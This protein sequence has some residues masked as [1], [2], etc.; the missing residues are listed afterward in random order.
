[1]RDLNVVV[2][3]YN[4]ANDLERFIKSFV[5]FPVEKYRMRMMVENVDPTIEERVAVDRIVERFKESLDVS[6]NHIGW[7]CGY[8]HAVNV[9]MG[10]LHEFGRDDILLACNADVEVCEAGSVD[11][12]CDALVEHHTWGVLGPR[13]TDGHGSLTHAGI[14]GVASKKKLVGWRS[15]GGF[16]YVDENAPSVSGSIYFIKGRLWDELSGCFEQS[17]A[18][19]FLLTPHY[20]E[21]TF[22]S[23]HATAHGWKVV[24]YGPRT[25]IHRWHRASPV[26]GW[27]E[28]Q[29]KTSLALYREACESLGIEHE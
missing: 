14:T 11:E 23:D 2:V 18:G 26:G 15:R 13:Q 27:A 16:T 28:R 10:K 24:Y 1:M 19:A 12:C 6:V 7:N 3:N 22:C 17:P 21:E 25:F 9:G 29:M 8:A 4:T 20:Y 5:E